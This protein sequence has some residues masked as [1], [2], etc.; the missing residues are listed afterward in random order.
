MMFFKN[1]SIR[2]KII[3]PVAL[4]GCLMIVLGIVSYQS[5]NQ[6][7]R[8]SDEITGNYVKSIERLD[9]TAIAYQT[10]RRVA[11]AHIVEDDAADK[12]ALVEEADSLKAEISG[13]CE[14]DYI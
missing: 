4:L 12:Q 6:L 3:I 7:M 2:H 10:L 5:A 11:F 13:L 9:D 1:L 14:R 8:A